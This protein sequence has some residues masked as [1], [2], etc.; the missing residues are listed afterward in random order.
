M[1]CGSSQRQK[2]MWLGIIYDSIIFL[3]FLQPCSSLDSAQIPLSS[4]SKEL[5]VC[6]IAGFERGKN[7]SLFF[8]SVNLFPKN[9]WF[10][11]IWSRPSSYYDSELSPHS[12]TTNVVYFLSLTNSLVVSLVALYNGFVEFCF[13]PSLSLLLFAITKTLLNFLPISARSWFNTMASREKP[14]GKQTISSRNTNMAFSQSY[15][16][17]LE[18]VFI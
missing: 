11:S 13:F 5:A 17:K 18:S 2:C 12:T 3:T 7:M 10:C 16:K 8:L 6:S 14:I 9:Y 15:L 4:V 1:T